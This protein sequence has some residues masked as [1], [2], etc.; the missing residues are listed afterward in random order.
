MKLL[1]RSYSGFT[2]FLYEIS[3][4]IAGNNSLS[5]I[6]CIV[7]T[8]ACV[9]LALLLI[10]RVNIYNEDNFEE[11]FT[12]ARTMSRFTGSANGIA[13][14]WM[15]LH[16]YHAFYYFRFGNLNFAMLIIGFTGYIFSWY[17]L[18]KFSD[19]NRK[20]NI[21]LAKANK[22]DPSIVMAE[23]F[24]LT[25][26]QR[27][28]VSM[29]VGNAGASRVLSGPKSDEELFGTIDD[30]VYDDPRTP[31][32]V[33]RSCGKVNNPKNNL[34]AY[35][36]MPL[37]KTNTAVSQKE[38]DEVDKILN[39]TKSVKK[40][41]DPVNWIL[42]SAGVVKNDEGKYVSVKKAAEKS[43]IGTP[44]INKS[45]ENDITVTPL[46]ENSISPHNPT[47]GDFSVTELKGTNFF[48]N[49]EDISLSES[50]LPEAE[51]KAENSINADYEKNIFSGGTTN[52][53]RCNYCGEMNDKNNAQCVYCGTILEKGGN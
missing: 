41:E 35:C 46:P 26:E 18:K 37:D 38:Q 17:A 15:F 13:G 20:H 9:F 43:E 8:L 19:A 11:N 39:G 16:C 45:P 25:Q 3:D 44:D 53:I 22:G 4:A 47:E 30:P 33:C 36:G 48:K 52:Q 6:V 31:R 21:D 1:V 40:D 24:G 10:S 12:N 7:L 50:N 23:N 49:G 32:I 51:N 28:A 5:Y 29:I 42:Q 2:S 14:L 27:D 34:C